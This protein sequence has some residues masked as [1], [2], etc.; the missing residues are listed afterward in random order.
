[1]QPDEVIAI[2][3]RHES[4]LRARGVRHAALFGS[5]ARGDARPSSDVDIMIEL[6]PDNRLDLFAYSGLMNDI[7]G[8]FPVR[9]DVV[10]RNALKPYLRAPATRDAI[11]A[12]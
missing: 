6:A 12:F 11:Y 5:V 9:V 8:L 4:T 3:R 10:D 7:A 1:M 2:L